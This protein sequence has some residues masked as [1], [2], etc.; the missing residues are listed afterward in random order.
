MK[1]EVESRTLPVGVLERTRRQ[2]IIVRQRCGMHEDTYVQLLKEFEQ[3]GLEWL[4]RSPRYIPIFDLDRPEGS[5]VIR[6]RV[7]DIVVADQTRTVLIGTYQIR[8]CTYT[9]DQP[10]YIFK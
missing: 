3:H 8:V 5:S 9:E 1:Q 6:F 4:R 10:E 2:E 7:R